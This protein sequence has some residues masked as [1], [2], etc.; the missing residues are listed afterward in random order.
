MA[1]TTTFKK[2][3]VFGDLRV[4]IIEATADAATAQLDSGL[5]NILGFSV[6]A[7]SLATGAPHIFHNAGVTG[8]AI[9]GALGCTGFVSGDTLFITVYGT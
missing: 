2:K 1:W 6:G 3:T 7:K 8:T 4:N 9:A 5:A